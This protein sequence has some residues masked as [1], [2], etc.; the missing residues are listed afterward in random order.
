[1]VAVA[2]CLAGTTLITQDTREAVRAG[3]N[4]I[5]KIGGKKL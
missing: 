5:K 2:I 1:M 4:T 3:F